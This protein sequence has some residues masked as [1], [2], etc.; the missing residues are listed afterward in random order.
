L[1]LPL[2]PVAWHLIFLLKISRPRGYG[3]IRVDGTVSFS[4]SSPPKA[5]APHFFLLFSLSLHLR[6]PSS[7]LFF[8]FF[9]QPSRIPRPFLALPPFHPRSKTR[10]KGNP[11]PPPFFWCARHG[12]SS[13]FRLFTVGLVPLPSVS[14]SGDICKLSPIK[15]GIPFPPFRDFSPWTKEDMP[16]FAFSLFPSL[17][18]PRLLESFFLVL[19]PFLN[20][21]RRTYVDFFPFF[22]PPLRLLRPPLFFSCGTIFPSS[23]DHAGVFNCPPSLPFSS[24]YRKLRVN[25]TG[26]FFP[27]P[28]F[29][30]TPKGTSSFFI[31]ESYGC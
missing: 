21:G 29:R 8:F 16:K 1:T 31:V 9:P 17:K 25:L 15:Q 5:T 24:F 18:D 20:P 13:S 6:Q 19:P 23:A 14:I 4:G 10:T 28:F 30:P 22:S 12:F 27:P 3:I 26:D 11:F 7:S 2:L